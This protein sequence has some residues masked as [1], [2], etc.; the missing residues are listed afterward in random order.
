MNN[1]DRMNQ[2]KLEVVLKQTKRSFSQWNSDTKTVEYIGDFSWYEFFQKFPPIK[3]KIYS[4]EYTRKRVNL[5]YK[6][7]KTPKI[8]YTIFYTDTSCYEVPKIVYDYYDIEEI[9]KG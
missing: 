5:E 9:C 7:H 1:L 4:E 2:G 6:K 3:K 8:I